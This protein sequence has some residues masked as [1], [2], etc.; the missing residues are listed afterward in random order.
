LEPTP[1]PARELAR[2]SIDFLFPSP[3]RWLGSCHHQLQEKLLM[4]KS[5]VLGMAVAATLVA[6]TVAACGKKPAPAPPAP[7]PPPPVTRPAPPPPPPPPPPPAPTP[8]PAAPTEEELFAKLTVDDLNNRK[9][10]GDVFFQLDSSELSDE[11][12]AYLQKNSEYLKK[13]TSTR[14]SV[15]GHCDERGTTEYN[16]GLGERRATSV[17]SYLVSLGV[18]A[19][20][21]ATVSKGKEQPACTE[22]NEGCWSKNRRG[23][24]IFTA[25]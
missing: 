15:E 2:A 11:A 22:S 16:L 7:P 21:L 4:S 1:E 20:R 5:R 9:P 18:A 23:H 6:M 24:F 8:E 19:D 25:K 10:L 12:R 13:W 17:K 14:V 3:D